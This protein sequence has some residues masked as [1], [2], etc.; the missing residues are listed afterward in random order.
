MIEILKFRGLAITGTHINAIRQIRYSE[1][2]N[3]PKMEE[4]GTGISTKY[5]SN[6]GSRLIIDS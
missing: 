1:K 5:F 6:P 3:Y 4:L 2:I